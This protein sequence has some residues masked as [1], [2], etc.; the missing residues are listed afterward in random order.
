MN[1]RERSV[2]WIRKT[3]GTMKFEH[4]QFNTTNVRYPITTRI[5]IVRNTGGLLMMMSKRSSFL[6]GFSIAESDLVS[7]L[8]A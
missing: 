3:K 7:S 4:L 1:A 6:R 2:K 8:F 5:E